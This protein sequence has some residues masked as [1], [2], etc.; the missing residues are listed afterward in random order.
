MQRLE[1]MER[2]AGTIVPS[3][4][5]TSVNSQGQRSRIARYRADAALKLR[6]DKTFWLAIPAYQSFTTDGTADNT[7]TFNLSHSVTDT[8]ATQSVVVWL[9]GDYYGSPDAVDYDADTID[10]TDAGTGSTVHVYY[11]SDAPCTLEVRKAVPDSSTRS[12]QRLYRSNV[13]LVHGTRQA[14]QGESLNVGG[15]PLKGFVAADMTID[16]YAKAPYTIRFED[17]DGDNTE[18]TNAMVNL[19]TIEGRGEVPGLKSAI[20]DGM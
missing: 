16:V 20:K 10:V 19:P 12:S 4:M 15:A 9:D 13:G 17:P 18:P 14:E 5:E 3:E 1:E 11:I 8:P 2:T 6:G 7:E